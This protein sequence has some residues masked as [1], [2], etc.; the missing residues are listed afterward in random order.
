MSTATQEAPVKEDKPKAAKPA[1]DKVKIS[2]GRL[3][4]VAGHLKSANESAAKADALIDDMLRGKDS[5]RSPIVA[6]VRALKET[7]GGAPAAVRQSNEQIDQIVA[8]VEE[9][10]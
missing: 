10:L 9:M 6:A 7:L 1:N 5:S 3:K 8:D 4:K 2:A